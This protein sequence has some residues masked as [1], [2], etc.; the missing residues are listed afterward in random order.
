MSTSSKHA[1]RF[2]PIAIVGQSCVLPGALNPDELWQAVRQGKSLISEAKE[3]EWGQST[4]NFLADA[5][6]SSESTPTDTIPK[7]KSWNT[8]LSS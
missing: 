2:E 8:S 4:A 3:N 5:G 6:E 1:G 7:D